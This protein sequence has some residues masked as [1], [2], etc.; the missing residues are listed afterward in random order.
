MLYT[1]YQIWC[2][3]EFLNKW[4][5]CSLVSLSEQKFERSPNSLVSKARTQLMK[6]HR[7]LAQVFILLFQLYFPTSNA[8]LVS[9]INTVILESLL[10]RYEWHFL[11]FPWS[12]LVWYDLIQMSEAKNFKRK[13]IYLT[14]H[15]VMFR[16]CRRGRRVT[17]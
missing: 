2:L 10:H 12:F 17:F 3:T 7:I 11:N 6:K 1:E 16:A 13:F 5:W 8:K 15:F 4:K 14:L 9:T